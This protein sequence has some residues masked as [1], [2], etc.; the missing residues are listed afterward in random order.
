MMQKLFTLFLLLSFRPGFAQDAF[1]TAFT[2]QQNGSSIKLIFTIA[3]G[4]TCNGIDIQR[5][6]NSIN[7]ETIG[8]I[9]GVCGSND[10]ET[11]YEFT[12]EHPLPNK[13]NYYR[14]VI[15]LIGNSEIISLRFSDFSNT[16]FYIYPNPCHYK[17]TIEF[18][19]S[20][21]KEYTFLL[22]DGLGHDCIIAK[23]TNSAFNFSAVTLKRGVHVFL[24]YNEDGLKEKGTLVVE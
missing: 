19:N 2:A 8:D 17:F 22:I 12:D 9:Q 11:S 3:K 21:H 18:E 23:T 14:L 15:P 20:K 4:K 24:L 6:A 7:F 1:V 13:T 16:S 5:S 10:I